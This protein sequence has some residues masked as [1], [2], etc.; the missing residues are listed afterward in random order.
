VLNEGQLI[1]EGTMPELKG[2]MRRNHFELQ[3][4]GKP[5][6]VEALRVNLA[7]LAPVRS[8]TANGT[9]I[10]IELADGKD[11][12]S[13]LAEV[14]MTVA[15]AGLGLVSVQTKGHQTEE[16]FLELVESDQARGFARATDAKAA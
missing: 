6:A 16:A 4:E 3:L 7:K 8:A 11:V 13:P 1:F 10:E 12:A 9:R 14:F 15:E 5:K 2:K